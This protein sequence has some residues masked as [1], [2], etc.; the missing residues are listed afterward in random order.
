MCT[1]HTSSKGGKRNIKCVVNTQYIHKEGKTH[2]Y[3][4]IT[5][6]P[7]DAPV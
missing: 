6:T 7:V 2:L 1:K 3:N 4:T 5:C